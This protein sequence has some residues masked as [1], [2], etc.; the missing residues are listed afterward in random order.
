MSIAFSETV[1]VTLSRRYDHLP[2]RIFENVRSP[3]SW[4]LWPGSRKVN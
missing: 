4:T 2:R 1:G 3:N